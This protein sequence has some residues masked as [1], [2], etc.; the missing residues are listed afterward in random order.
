MKMNLYI[1][2][3]ARDIG[4]AFSKEKLDDKLQFDQYLKTGD[5]MMIRDCDLN[6]WPNN[7]YTQIVCKYGIAYTYNFKI[8]DW[9]V[10]KVNT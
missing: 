5:V 7:D 1:I 10:K 2:V 6:V 3:V 4:V 9:R 8:N